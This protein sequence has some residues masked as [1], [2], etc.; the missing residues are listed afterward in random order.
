M[1][2]IAS[3][4]IIVSNPLKMYAANTNIKATAQAM[5]SLSGQALRSDDT[6]NERLQKQKKRATPFP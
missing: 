1:A 6:G 2:T 5:I 4:I 3:A